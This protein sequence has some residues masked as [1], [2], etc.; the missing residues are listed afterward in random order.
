MSPNDAQ[1]NHSPHVDT[2]AAADEAAPLN[3]PAP[4]ADLY[5]PLQGAVVQTPSQPAAADRYRQGQP[6]LAAA[7][8]GH[9]GYM[10]NGPTNQ[11]SRSPRRHDTQQRSQQPPTQSGSRSPPR[12]AP[13]A[14]CGRRRSTAAPPPSA[15][16]SCAGVP[17]AAGP[18]TS[19]R[20][21]WHPTA[22]SFA[23]STPSTECFLTRGIEFSTAAVL[24]IGPVSRPLRTEPTTT[25]TTTPTT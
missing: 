2:P 22:S 10:R 8:Q 12:G 16:A 19:A 9:D 18:T 13:L 11:R 25:T 1:N 23:S 24:S 20:F 6:T 3:P 4:A 14:V 15:C 7:P 21:T 17:C 5:R